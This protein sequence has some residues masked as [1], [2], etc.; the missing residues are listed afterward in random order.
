V[1]ERFP[2]FTLRDQHNQEVN[3][4][5]ARDGRRALLVFHRSTRW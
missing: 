3:L 2:D 1:G 4:M 5:R